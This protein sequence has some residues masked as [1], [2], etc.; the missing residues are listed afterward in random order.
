MA[1]RGDLAGVRRLLPKCKEAYIMS[2]SMFRPTLG[3][4]ALHTALVFQQLDIAD[5]IL[6]R[7]KQLWEEQAPSDGVQRLM[8]LLTVKDAVSKTTTIMLMCRCSDF[9]VCQYF[10]RCLYFSFLFLLNISL[11]FFRWGNENLRDRV[12]ELLKIVNHSN[13]RF[14]EKLEAVF[15]HR[16]RSGLT[17]LHHAVRSGCKLAVRWCMQN[18]AVAVPDSESSENSG[19]D[20]AASAENSGQGDATASAENSGQ[21]DATGQAKIPKSNPNSRQGN[22]TQHRLSSNVTSVIL[23]GTSKM[24]KSTLWEYDRISHQ[25]QWVPLLF[26]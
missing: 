10:S 2:K 4:D 23:D 21:G 22:T 6:E 1:C 19:G 15:F 14:P 8:K 26:L 3:F 13:S 24:T 7:V 5:A 17:A 9:V 18:G 16:D 20:A 11:V 25:T 12:V